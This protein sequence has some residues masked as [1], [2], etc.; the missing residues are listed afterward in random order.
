[1]TAACIPF[2][3]SFAS[4]GSLGL[5]GLP[6]A[7]LEAS[8]LPARLIAAGPIGG[9]G[10]DGP[11]G[12]ATAGDW[13]LLLFYLALALCVSFLCS[14]LEAGFLSL[15]RS[16]AR[17]MA[18]HGH[19]FGELLNEMKESVD[20]PLAAILT[21]NTVSHTFGAAGVGA[22]IQRI[23]GA[24]WLTAGSVIV[25]LLILVLSE[26]LPKT[27]GAVHAKKL[28]PFTAHAIRTIIILT[29]P[30]VL[31]L[32]LMSRVIGG[33]GHPT[34]TRAEMASLAEEGQSTGVLGERESRV[35]TNMLR[36]DAIRVSDVMT[37][38]PVV[39]MLPHHMTVAEATGRDKPIPF[40]RIP[41]FRE[42]P[43]EVMGFV[44]RHD[45]FTNRWEGRGSIRL[46]S[47]VQ[48]LAVIPA[49][50]SVGQAL[51]L[52]TA[53]GVHMMLVVD[54]FGG[55]AGIITLE[56]AVETLLGVEIV[57]ETDD[58]TDMRA[59]ARARMERRRRDRERRLAGPGPTLL[60]P[61]VRDAG[62]GTEAGAG[63][64]AGTRAAAPITGETG[65]TPSA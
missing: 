58:V 55:T 6:P 12:P 37:P 52:F 40:S 11:A 7:L 49:M 30:I 63:A 35:I 47:L 18:D 33:S 20:R 32:E 38:R 29:Y 10:D 17:V 59:L 21:L 57:D 44:L 19:R 15:P 5:A 3:G 53:K 39:F 43:D 27:L 4:F 50:A 54:E 2:L 65:N 14:L 34:I 13:F 22:M 9:G 26:I 16:H 31:C 48:D 62:A 36:L 1:M 41:I 23:F 64:G 28:A 45:L 25:T 56:D 42:N 8:V 51:E 24:A 61:P 46:A 60:T